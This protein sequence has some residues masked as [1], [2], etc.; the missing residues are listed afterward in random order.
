MI[1]DLASVSVARPVT[2]APPKK[3][4]LLPPPREVQ[5][6]V[7]TRTAPPK[8]LEPKPPE[9]KVLPRKMKQKPKPR[10]KIRKRHAKARPESKVTMSAPDDSLRDLR[11]MI[12]SRAR[13]SEAFRPEAR[14]STAS[15][16]DI[17]ASYEAALMA[18]LRKR[19]FYPKRA[20]RRGREGTVQVGFDILADGR[21][22]NIRL[23]KSSGVKG[24][25]NAALKVLRSIGRFKP[26]PEAL[27]M[28]RWSLQVPMEYRLRH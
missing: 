4:P 11:R 27:G 16:Q 18:E 23:V 10:K 7:E 8:A 5:P 13:P 17:R 2:S 14:P 15:V 3:T 24:L 28:R 12:A 9:P 6:P 20:L 1:I 21:L 19:R 26:L 25:D 22:E